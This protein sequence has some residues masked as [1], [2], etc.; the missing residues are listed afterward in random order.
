MVPKKKAK[1]KIQN[2]S[3]KNTKHYSEPLL[4]G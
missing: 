1:Q 3:Q 2:L 4:M